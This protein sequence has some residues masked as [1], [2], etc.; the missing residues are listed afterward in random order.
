VPVAPESRMAEGGWG[1]GATTDDDNKFGFN[2]RVML[3]SVAPTC[4]AL[5][6]VGTYCRFL[7]EPPCMLWK[8]AAVLCPGNCVLHSALV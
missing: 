7:V 3:V 2:L 8:V 5:W 1:G 6:L 4:Q